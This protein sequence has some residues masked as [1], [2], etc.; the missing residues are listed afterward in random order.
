MQGFCCPLQQR[1]GSGRVTHRV[2]PQ[3]RRGG[4]ERLTLLNSFKGILESRAKARASRAEVTPQGGGRSMFPPRDP[5]SETAGECTT[6]HLLISLYV[7][8]VCETH[9]FCLVF[10][11]AC[12]LMVHLFP[13]YMFWSF[14]KFSGS[15]WIKQWDFWRCNVLQ[16]QKCSMLPSTIENVSVFVNVLWFPWKTDTW[17]QQLTK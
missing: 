15:D 2:A 16:C 4:D 6:Y 1:A 10:V 17:Q 7:Y 12:T 3:S 8:S 9:I 14:I 5:V 11:I 13:V